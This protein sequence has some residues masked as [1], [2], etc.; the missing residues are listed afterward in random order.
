MTQRIDLPPGPALLYVTS[1]DADGVSRVIEVDR[2]P[3]TDARERAILKGLLY[4]AIRLLEASEP[5]RGT[6]VSRP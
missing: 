1:P 6:A 4:H 3:V 5:S 2:E